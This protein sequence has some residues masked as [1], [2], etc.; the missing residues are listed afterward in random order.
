VKAGGLVSSFTL[1]ID[2]N[3]SVVVGT[4]GPI[5]RAAG[6]G[7]RQGRP[8]RSRLHTLDSGHDSHP[9]DW[10]HGEHAR[11]HGH[12]CRVRGGCASCCCAT[13]D[14]SASAQ[15]SPASSTEGVESG[16]T[17]GSKAKTDPTDASDGKTPMEQAST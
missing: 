3:G 4:G 5:D 9:D 2:P 11:Q 14:S 13:K 16:S 12:F 10:K 15:T 7:R 8:G 6:V 17:K 1:S